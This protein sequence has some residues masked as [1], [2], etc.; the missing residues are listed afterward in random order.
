MSFLDFFL[1]NSSASSTVYSDLY[2]YPWS[3]TFSS[4]LKRLCWL[5]PSSMY[6]YILRIPQLSLRSLYFH[7]FYKFSSNLWPSST[8]STFTSDHVL[9]PLYSTFT[10]D[11]YL[12]LWSWAFIPLLN[13]HLQTLPWLL[14]SQLLGPRH[15]FPN[16]T[17]ISVFIFP[18]WPLSMRF[19]LCRKIC[20]IFF[21]IH[22]LLWNNPCKA[23]LVFL[24]GE[25]W[26]WSLQERKN[27]PLFSQTSIVHNKTRWIKICFFLIYQCVL[28]KEVFF[29]MTTV[30]QCTTL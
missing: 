3:H 20:S 5:L 2:L 15:S 4:A 6:S 14:I 29:G 27:L 25:P 7:R 26:V 13:L 1:R 10:Y 30:C 23:A 8:T 11:I 28:S 19:Y 18:I 24:P 9:Y 16:F 21:S 17:F 12:C 22:T